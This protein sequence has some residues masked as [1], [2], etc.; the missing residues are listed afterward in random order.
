MNP[1]TLYRCLLCKLNK[2]LVILVYTFL[3]CK[4][5][6]IK[7]CLVTNRNTCWTCLKK[8]TD[9]PNTYKEK[10]ADLDDFYDSIEEEFKDIYYFCSL[11]CAKKDYKKCRQYTSRFY[12]KGSLIKVI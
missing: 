3:G 6:N 11:K 9:E 4:P 2:E 1:F 7:N 5:K 12:H 10:Y 8:I